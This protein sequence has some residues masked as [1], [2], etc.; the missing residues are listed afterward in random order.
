MNNPTISAGS[1]FISPFDILPNVLY[2]NPTGINSSQFTAPFTS[3][4]QGG[5]AGPIT[6]PTNTDT[7]QFT[8]PFTNGRPTQFQNPTQ[9][10]S[11]FTAPFNI[12][13]DVVFTGFA[14][15]TQN[16][17]QFT[18]PYPSQPQSNIPISSVEL[19]NIQL[20]STLTIPDTILINA[21]L[22]QK[23][24]NLGARNWTPIQSTYTNVTLK[25]TLNNVFGFASMA[26]ASFLGFPQIGQVGESLL[27]DA[28]LSGTYT[29]LPLDK[30]T[31]KLFPGTNINSPVLYPD[32]RS[33]LNIDKDTA[34]KKGTAALA[35]LTS[36][37]LD[38]TSAFARGSG[39]AGIYAAAVVSP[40]GPYSIFNLDGGGKTGYGWGEHDD[41]NAIRKDFTMRSHVAKRWQYGST[42]NKIP[43]KFITTN[44]PVEI[45]TPFRGDKV[46][47]IDFGSR[48][49]ADAYLWKSSNFGTKNKNLGIV[50]N[51]LG[52]TQDFIKFFF[53]GPKLQAGNTT[54]TD[55]IIVFRAA[56]T[57]LSD[58]FSPNW[59]AINMIGRADPNYIYGGYT[60][61]LSIGF[62]IYATDRD[63]MQPIYRKLNALAGY[64]APTYDPESIAM[65]GPWMRI[66][67][68]DLFNQTPV[69]LNSLS[70]DYGVT[71]AP[72]EINIEDDPNMMQVPFKISVTMAFNVISD[73][74]PQKGGRFYTLAKNF[75]EYGIPKTGNDNWLSDSKQ[76][77]DAEELAKRD[78]TRKNKIVTRTGNQSATP[79]EVLTQNITPN[80]AND[81]PADFWEPLPN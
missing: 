62:D 40:A 81:L 21:E 18:S 44:N 30:L 52:I 1:Q 53:T 2:T 35:Y 22:L 31:T 25:T 50:L 48:T 54:D 72:W 9:N 59:S 24:S 12:L 66:T 7:S 29:T 65:E 78:K 60:R 49:L 23:N 70:Y 4:L 14:N 39:K 77:I 71:E 46:S 10:N 41:Q 80:S 51:K 3:Y 11:Q 74:L 55:D 15:P 33:R 57:N 63:E 45:A 26:G 27:E 76:N 61:D 13:P 6:N 28:S 75:A 37:R 20:Y 68:G 19:P 38:G 36:R 56:I 69:I 43:G 58:S 17:S 5:F 32:F 42:I 16:N 47:V 64:T 8:A 79:P 73:Y 67:I 34:G